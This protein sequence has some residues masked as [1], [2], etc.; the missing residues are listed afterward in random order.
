MQ[1]ASSVS[2]EDEAVTPVATVKPIQ[3]VVRCI[4]EKKGDQWQAFS[5]EFGLA[6]Q[7]DTLPQVK[8]KLDLMLRSYVFDALLGEDR[9]HAAALMSRKATFGVYAKYYSFCALSFVST[10]KDR[11][12]YREPMPLGPEPCPA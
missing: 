2:R 6:V 7:G 1:T 5:L 9:A 3:L 4:A 11:I 12:L 8:H 10:L